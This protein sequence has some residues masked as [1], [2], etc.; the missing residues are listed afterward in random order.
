MRMLLDTNVLVYAINPESPR[1][2]ASAQVLREA[3][4]GRIQA[5]IAI[6]SIHEFYSVVTNEKLA[7]SPFTPGQA[8]MIATLLLQ[9]PRIEK[10]AQDQSTTRLALSLADELGVSGPRFFDCLL[11][12]SAKQH[13]VG[14]I[15]TENTRDFSPYSF[16][17]AVQPGSDGYK[18][19]T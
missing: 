15:L 11:A 12:A 16:L 18:L 7:P 1:H 17:E 10:L 5:C 6:Q 2:A 13:N 8:H 3:L 9:T 19:S 4:T 14:I